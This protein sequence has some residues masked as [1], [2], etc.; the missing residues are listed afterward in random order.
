MTEGRVCDD[1]WVCVL[2]ERQTERKAFG[3]EAFGS[4]ARF[5]DQLKLLLCTVRCATVF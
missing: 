2:V 3:S 5:S 4:L 1:V